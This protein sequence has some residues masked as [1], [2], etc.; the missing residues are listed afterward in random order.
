MVKNSSTK[1][2]TV[3][4]QEVCKP[5]PL[6]DYY[7][8]YIDLIG[9]RQIFSE[10][11]DRIKDFLN[12][13][14][15]LVNAFIERAKQTNASLGAISSDGFQYKIFSDNFLICFPVPKNADRIS[16]VTFLR[17]IAD[18]QRGFITEYRMFVRGGVTIGQLSFNENYIFGAGLIKAVDLEQKARLPRIIVDKD[19]RTL[20]NG[21]E[22][23]EG[24]CNCDKCYVKYVEEL[25]G[26]IAY[27]TLRN[28][29]TLVDADGECF[30]SY[31][32]VT[33]QDAIIYERVQGAGPKLVSKEILEACNNYADNKEKID[34]HYKEAT[35]DRL[36][37]HRALIIAIIKKYCQDFRLDKSR[38]DFQAQVKELQKRVCK[39]KWVVEY[40]NEICTRFN[41]SNLLIPFVMEIV[42]IM[43]Y[44]AYPLLFIIKILEDAVEVK[45]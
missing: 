31:L 27:L 18:I 12:D 9:Y 24:A 17:I 10:Q 40:H 29:T 25:K 33:N 1:K 28:A 41:H 13:I 7:I 38:T 43:H 15:N 6:K 45:S 37:T 14:H 26:E 42:P 21:G 32:D 44:D 5:S 34:N 35:L 23:P 19:L 36:T 8:A 3:V 4:S 22:V 20:L 2:K 16:H 39:Y 30:L 11:P